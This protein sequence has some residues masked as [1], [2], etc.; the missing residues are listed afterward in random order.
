MLVLWNITLI[1]QNKKDITLD[2]IWKNS[3]FRSETVSGISSMQDGLHYTT[4]SDGAILRYEYKSGKLIDTVLSEKWLKESISIGDY[5]FNS[6]ESRIIIKTDVVPIY[7]RS[8]KAIYYIYNRKTKEMTPVSDKG[9]QQYASLSPAG[10]R[11]AFA[12]DNNLFVK[13]L[14]NG[15]EKQITTDGKINEIING[16]CDWVYEEE[17]EFAPAFFWNA[18][19]SSIAY[20]RFD[21]SKVREYQ[22]AKYGKLY[23]EEYVYKYPKAGEANS[24]IDIFIYDVKKSSAI[25]VDIGKET[26]IYIPRLKWTQDPNTLCVYRMNR[27]QNKLELL[28]ADSK[29]GTTKPLMT[30]ENKFYIDINDNMIFMKDKQ[31]FI[32]SSEKEGFNQLYLYKMN[33]TLEN[34]ITKDNVDVSDFYGVDEINKIAYYQAADPNPMERHIFSVKLDGTGKKMLTTKKGQDRADFSSNYKYFINFHSDANT[35]SYI[36]LNTSDGKEVRV[37]EDNSKLNKKLADYNITPK[38]FFKFKTSEGIELNGWMIK[39]KNFDASKKY[40]VF[41]TVYGGPGINTVNDTWEGGNYLWEQMISENGYIIVSIDNRGTGYRG[42]QFKK[43]TYLNLGK[44][45]SDDQIEAAKYLKTLP[46][47]N[48]DRIG[49]FGW[50]YGG[51]MTSL[52]MTKGADYFK[53]GIAVAPVTNWRYYDNIYTERYMQTPQENQKGYD[54]NSPIAF[55]D[56]MKGKFLLV[57]GTADD[58]VHFQNSMEF[59]TALIK[60]NKQ[61][62]NFFYPNKNHGIYGGNTRMHLYTM[63]TDFIYKNL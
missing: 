20:Y 13:D 8:Y 62:E 3:T 49:I 44:F 59:V 36:T 31:H 27:H 33:G 14:V 53:A 63:M 55:V 11:V 40:P 12:R 46:Y 10:D 41:M 9:K 24:L 23:P 30:E 34:K 45:E 60:A 58:N 61:F 37:L 51:Y 4:Y 42:E 16:S 15:S 43:C 7:R 25:K 56:K 28:L 29:T 52:C 26:D 38:E 22:I 32:W 6:D 54:D 5:E 18:D 57:H 1:A 19:G 50:S 35:P 48:G 2:D 39:P 17:F 21:E 47:V